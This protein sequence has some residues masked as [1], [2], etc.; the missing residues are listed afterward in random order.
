LN[1]GTALG[2]TSV[3][4]VQTA[5]KP[6]KKALGGYISGPGSGTSDSIPA[7]LSNGEFVVNAAATA[8]NRSVLEAINYGRAK[9][10]EHRFMPTYT[11]GS[12][13]VQHVDRS[14]HDNGQVVLQGDFGSVD[15]ALSAAKA[16]QRDNI[17]MARLSV[18]V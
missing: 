14:V 18:S 16:R 6:K 13:P 8:A 7:L 1:A 9:I 2:K 17:T 12:S 15:R 3:G 10:N 5:A 4:L 11:G